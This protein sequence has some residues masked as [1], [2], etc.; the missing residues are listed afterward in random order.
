MPPLTP[1]QRT[2]LTAA[3]AA[4][5]VVSVAALTWSV[6]QLTRHKSH[7]SSEAADEAP[8]RWT[9]AQVAAWLQ[10]NGVSK[11]AAN[12][13]QRFHLNGEALLRVTERDLYRMGVPLRD[14]RVVLAAVEDLKESP[15][16]LSRASQAATSRQPSLASASS[17]PPVAAPPAVATASPSERF[18]AAWNALVRTCVLPS[19]AAAPAEQQQRVVVYTSA[20][21]ECFQALSPREQ[22]TALALVASAEDGA[23]M[24]PASATRDDASPPPSAPRAAAGVSEAASAEPA[25]AL[26]AVEAKL[27]PLHTMVDGF[28]EFLQSPEMDAVPPEDF[29][30]LGDRVVGQVKRVVR[31]CEQLPS[32]MSTPLLRKCERV[33]EVLASRRNVSAAVTAASQENRKAIMEALYDVIARVK[34][35]SLRSLPPAQQ[36]ETLTSLAKRAE[37]IERLSSGAV[38]GVAKDEQ[39]LKIVQPVLQLIREAVRVSLSEAGVDASTPATRE[40]AAEEDAE[41]EDAE[42]PMT[43]ADIPVIVETIRKIQQTLQSPEFR[44]APAEVRAQLCAVLS[45]R[46]TALEDRTGGLP[47][48][49]QNAVR[50]LLQNTQS[51]LAAVG[52][53]AAASA[54]GATAEGEENDAAEEEDE[55]EEE[56]EESAEADADESR[57]AQQPTSVERYVEQLERIFEFLTSE[58]LEHAPAEERARMAAELMQ[59]VDRIRT[60][61]AGSAVEGPIV[62]QLIEPLY[63]LLRNMAT[64]QAPSRQFVEVTAPLHDVQEL[65]NSTAF[66]QAP[67]P[68]KMRI[69]RGI[70]P[71]LQQL[72]ATFAQLSPSERAGAEELVRPISE[73]LLRI[74]RERPATQVSAQSVL[75]GLQSVMRTIQGAE[76]TTMSPAARGAWAAKAVGDLERLNDDCVALG[77]EGDAL[78]PIVQRLERQL[79]GLFEMAD[80]AGAAPQENGSTLWATVRAMEAELA[81][82]DAEGTFVAPSRLQQML[83]VLGDA[84]DTAD[85]TAEEESLLQHFGDDLR[86]H[87]EGATAVSPDGEAEDAAAGAA[88]DGEGADD[89]DDALDSLRVS[90]RTL[91][92][93]AQED[94]GMSGASLSAIAAKTEELIAAADEAGVAWRSDAASARAVKGI[95]D[96]L[97]QSGLSAEQ[98][99]GAAAAGGSAASAPS[100][101]E[102]VLQSSIKAL[103]ESPP[104]SQEEFAPFMRVLQLA[105]PAAE[106]MTNRELVLLKTLQEAVIESMRAM[107]EP[108]H[109]IGEAGDADNGRVAPDD[110]GEEE[111]EGDEVDAV[112][113]ALLDMSFK[114]RDGSY[115]AEQLDEFEAIQHDLQEL[116]AQA[117][118]DSAEA[119]ASVREQIRLQRKAL[120][121]AEGKEGEEEEG[122]EEEASE[123]AEA[124]EEGERR[125]RQE[126]REGTQAFNEDD[127]DAASEGAVMAEAGKS[128]PRRAVDAAQEDDAGE[129][130]EEE[131]EEGVQKP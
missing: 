110:E 59:R 114:L 82:A 8:E 84:A 67:H 131:E 13:C 17:H 78:R 50:E 109:P 6:V 127:D 18:E 36:V 125:Q 33:F 61:V 93:V 14:A 86:R 24:T 123:R 48:P 53:T 63:D 41:E 26:R 69:A 47:A 111:E 20:L 15:V 128:A 72:T 91:L 55:A 31:V 9:Q 68:E 12:L 3:A 35:P 71:Q 19:D 101:V 52:N 28:L 16:L 95:L 87:V 83:T 66:Q 62:S 37:S 112:L 85:T 70:V 88:E 79:R 119:M 64:M 100:K 44:Q 60:E 7:H 45:Q 113:D 129:E 118:V 4:G 40:A 42:K 29:E 99:S 90:L 81:R 121:N 73:E 116:L 65:L 39:V 34:D 22:T 76:F 43:S 75:D 126:A 130:E 54:G 80:S 2:A 10:E 117:G 103:S 58:A 49:T 57:A 106:H 38:E 21:L 32:E 120:L 102:E 96:L 77:P 25:G 11:A 56:E 122:E 27:Q 115:T 1:P 97:Q 107:P 89:E 94:D 105:Q 98:R 23:A 74:V 46:I 124:A 5:A 51:V 108:P 30:E 92:D 104:T